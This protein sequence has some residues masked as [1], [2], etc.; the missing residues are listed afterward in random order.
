MVKFDAKKYASTIKILA[1]AIG[2][3]MKQE[4][5]K[6]QTMKIDISKSIHEN[7]IESAKLK[8]GEI[9]RMRVRCEAMESLKLYVEQLSYDVPLLQRSLPT[10]PEHL[11]PIVSAI[12]FASGYF[13]IKQ[14]HELADMIKGSYGKKWFEEALSSSSKAN[15]EFKDKVTFI[16]PTQIQIDSVIEEVKEFDQKRN[17]LVENYKAFQKSDGP[18][19]PG[20]PSGNNNGNQGNGGAVD[21]EIE[22]MRKRLASL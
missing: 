13:A 1:L 14:L 17:Q 6:D 8:A 15:I 10:I 16:L 21:N 18:D 20:P 7:K 19:V 2:Q 4:E 11:V 12:V 5:A 3:F 9:V 22:A